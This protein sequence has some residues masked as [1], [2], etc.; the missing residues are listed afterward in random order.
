MTTKITRLTVLNIDALRTVLRADLV[1]LG[2]TTAEFTGA[3][4]AEAL[5]ELDRAMTKAI[6]KHG[7]KGHPVQSLHA[8]RRKLVR[9]L[10][11][12]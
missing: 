6:L 8:V 1:R 3:D 5:A 11:V 4:P 12:E 9:L 2:D 7:A 10:P